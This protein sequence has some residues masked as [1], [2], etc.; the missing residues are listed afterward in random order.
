MEIVKTKPGDANFHLFETLP[1]LLYA[2]DSI[3]HKQSETINNEFLDACYVLIVNNE[4]NARLAVY[5]NPYLI[6][7]GKN[8]A[9]LGNY[10]CI[11]NNEIAKKIIAFAIDEVKKTGNE[12]LIGPMNGSTW[13]NYR[14][15]LH[16]EH[17]N[18]LL[19]PYH[20]I[21]YNDHFLNS[22]F[23]PISN[24]SSSIDRD[25]PCDHEEVSKL[26]DKFRDSGIKIRNINMNDYDKELKKLYNFTSSSF[27]SNFLYT[28]IS[29]ETFSSKYKSVAKIINPEY[30]LIAEDS[31]GNIIGFIFC[32]DDLF[33]PTEKS[34]VIKSLARDASK[35]WS[36]LGHV[37][38]NRIIRLV[39]S[40]NYQSVVHAF[41]IEQGTSTSTSNHFLG[42]KYKKY[43]LY[44]KEI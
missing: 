14:F 31:V 37:L 16:H 29:W 39:K 30:F 24:Y 28:P 4:P 10:E 2:P 26:E 38:V 20:P 42:K 12:Y 15:S 5:N 43:T 35:K 32:Y 13:D 7:K 3:R 41:M 22:G 8:S 23:K 19:E 40:K 27:K 9:C 1:K 17:P 18:F 44:G 33:N 25:M 21:Y 34:L 11:D 36:G 6:Y